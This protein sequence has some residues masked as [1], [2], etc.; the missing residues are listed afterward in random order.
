MTRQNN[1]SF[2]SAPYTER[3]ITSAS[4][5]TF[6]FLKTQDVTPVLDAAKDARE[7][8][9]RDTGPIQG[10][11]LGTVPVLVAQQW[12]KECGAA[13]GTK[14]WAAYAKKKLADGTWAKLRVH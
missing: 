3:L 1:R 4:D 5:G 6:S 9:R 7:H 2:P 13:I 11:Y 14:E 12:A 10:R 8:L